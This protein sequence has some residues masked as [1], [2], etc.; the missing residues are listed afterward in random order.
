MC[1]KDAD[2]MA[3]RVD[4]DPLEHFNLGLPCLPRPVCLNI[5]K[6]YS[7]LGFV[8][9]IKRCTNREDSGPCSHHCPYEEVLRP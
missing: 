8:G 1:Q 3:K 7:M 5:D 6:Q 2:E 9:K 4:P